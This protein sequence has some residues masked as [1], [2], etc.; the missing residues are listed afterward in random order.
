MRHGVRIGVDVGSVRVG[1]AA[2]DPA[3]VLA[4]PVGTFRRS[5]DAADIRAVAELAAE[6]AAIEVVVGLPLSMDGTEQAAA[7]AARAWANELRRLGPGLAVRLVDERLTTVDAH[8]A[9]R[10][11]GLRAR[12]RREIVDQQAAVLILQA[13]LDS[14]RVSGRP[15]GVVLGARKPR[16]TKERQRKAPE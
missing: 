16:H 10:E 1:V 13:A 12:D 3:G 2:C 8:R 7:E 4:T 15:A 5:G 9:M 11:S 6:R 14:E